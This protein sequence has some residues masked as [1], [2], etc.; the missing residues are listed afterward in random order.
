VTVLDPER[1]SRLLAVKLA[2]LAR[3]HLGL[4][5]EP[6]SFTGGAALSVGD[7]AVVLAEDD[8][9]RALG[10][11]LAWA[12]Q[13]GA[14]SVDL[15][16]AGEAG[17]VARR[18]AAFTTPPAVW[19]ADGRDLQPADPEPLPASPPPPTGALD[20]VPELAAA[21]AEVVV[22]HGV[23]SGE[24]LGLEIARVVAG[25][26][27]LRIEAG[28][29]RHDREAYAMLHGEIPT[30]QALANVIGAV[31]EARRADRPDHPLQRLAPER[32]LRDV[33]VADPSLVGA[34]HLERHEG[35]LPRPSV[36]DPWPAVSIGDGLVVVCSVGIDL[37]L[38]PF[39]SDARLAVDPSARLVLVVP[40]RDDHPVTRA[41]AAALRQPADV[42]TVPGDWREGAP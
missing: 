18:A 42:V 37:E 28:V 2:T 23:V 41:L 36:K 27:G 3:E 29:G 32:W 15:L 25:E 24:V 31:R 8:P 14:A 40:E 6:A 33:V 19:L 7:R 9:G 4:E 39:A 30:A 35:P 17:Q 16:V 22:E 21:G 20:L 10:R 12:R 11:A 1:R 34:V 5:G 26:D 38:V 13:A